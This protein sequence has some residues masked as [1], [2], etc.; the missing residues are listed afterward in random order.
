MSKP[1]LTKVLKKRKSRQDFE[2]KHNVNR[3]RALTRITT[4]DID[5]KTGEKKDRVIKYR[6]HHQ[7]GHEPM[8]YP[9]SK[10]NIPCQAK[11]KRAKKVTEDLILS[12]RIKTASK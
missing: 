7:D 8:P 12:K 1:S 10:K 5:D 9:E 2:L 4:V 6:K 3:N 11:I